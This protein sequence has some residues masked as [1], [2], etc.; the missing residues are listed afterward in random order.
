[1]AVLGS[2]LHTCYASSHCVQGNLY[3]QEMKAYQNLKKGFCVHQV[4]SEKMMQGPA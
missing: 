3:Y 4:T 2:S 1:M